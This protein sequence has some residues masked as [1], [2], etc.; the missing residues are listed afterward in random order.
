MKVREKGC[1][2]CG[3]T[4]GD[5]WEEVEGQRM[6]FCCDVCAKEFIKM[7][8]EVKR[9]TGWERIEEIQMEGNYRGRSCTAIQ[10]ANRYRFFIR[11]EEGGDVQ[12]LIELN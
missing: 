12:S 4:W 11:F 1:V 10:G 8:G 3:A 2:I 6:F 9:R 7:V 5:Y